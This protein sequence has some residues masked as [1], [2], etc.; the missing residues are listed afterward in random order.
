ML[1]LRSKMQLWLN[2]G[3]ELMGASLLNKMGSRLV[4]KRRSPLTSKF[5]CSN[6]CFSVQNAND[7]PACDDTRQQSSLSV[8]IAT[9]H[10]KARTLFIYWWG[11]TAEL[12]WQHCLHVDWKK[13][14]VEFNLILSSD[15]TQSTQL[16][17]DTLFLINSMY[18]L[19]KNV[20][21]FRWFYSVQLLHKIKCKFK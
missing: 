21:S 12:C 4:W 9:S 10:N 14:C 20:S 1:W 2:P 15:C 19:L 18:S 16:D 8:R 13:C 5:E 3:K 6:M 11:I 17:F 7:K